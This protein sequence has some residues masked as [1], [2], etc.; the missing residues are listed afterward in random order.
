MRNRARRFYSPDLAPGEEIDSIRDAT[1]GGTGTM[2]GYGALIGALVGWLI[3][4]ALEAAALPWF[5]LG[6]LTGEAV[7][8]F[9]AHRKARRPDGP[10]T[11]H[12]QL[13]ATNQRLFTVRRYA[14]SK[15]RILRSYPFE[16]YT[17]KVAHRYPIG[18][19]IRLDITGEDS[20]T[21]SL[22]TEGP[23]ELP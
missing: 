20:P 2:V 11:I 18:R 8:Y 23:I 22:V 4:M 3:A 9:L 21:V 15:R 1:A 16:Q 5:V 13:V 6:A 14:S 12:L 19:Y 17:A 7:G 10:G